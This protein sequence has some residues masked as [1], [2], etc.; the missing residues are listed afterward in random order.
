MHYVTGRSI[1]PKSG[2]HGESKDNYMR[3]FLLS[4]EL[5]RLEYEKKMAS[6]KITNLEKRIEDIRN[7]ISSINTMLGTPDEFYENGTDI[8][9]LK[10]RHITMEY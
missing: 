5:S 3:A 6:V 1:Y 8:Q 2:L 9:N 7:E 10:R 4:N